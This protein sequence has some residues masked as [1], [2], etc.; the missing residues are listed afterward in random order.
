AGWHNKLSALR[1]PRIGI[2]SNLPA[3]LRAELFMVAFPK[4]TAKPKA[5]ASPTSLSP[6]WRPIVGGFS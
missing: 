5:R 4:L 6:P 3:H 1:R 2:F